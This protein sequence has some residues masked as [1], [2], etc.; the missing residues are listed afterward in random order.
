[1]SSYSEHAN[2]LNHLKK[3]IDGSLVLTSSK[4]VYY[5][6]GLMADGFE[7]LI[8][9]VS[10][11]DRD[12]LLVPSL[13]A[14]EALELN[15]EFEVKAW[16]DSQ[17]STKLLKDILPSAGNIYVESSMK[18]GLYSELPG[19]KKFL[20]GPIEELR[21]V[22]EE[23]EINRMKRA[24]EIAEKSFEE[25]IEEIGEGISE[26]R[27]GMILEQ[28]F[29]ENGAQKAAF[30]SIVAFGK[31]AANP[32]HTPDQTKLH[33]G[34]CIIIDFGCQYEHYNSD[35]T[36]TLYLGT[37]P[38]E[39]Q[40]VYSVVQ[41]AQQA[42]CMFLREGVSGKQT[43]STVRSHIEKKGYG[44]MFFHRTGHGIGL[45]VH[46]SPYVDQ[47]NTRPLISGNCVSVEP[48]IYLNGRFGVRI[49]D[50]LSVRSGP[51]LNFNTL[52]KDLIVL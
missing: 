5:F 39:F 9:F 7:R 6:S 46:E 37:P 4:N 1:M 49:E 2:R 17:N 23:T 45:D 8:A 13:H 51:A 43:D 3:K 20:D 50:I 40:D 14:A 42:G 34:E 26:S 12:V 25:T 15:G 33:N 21:S 18:A 36:R 41:E 24:S 44:E 28:K 48:G 47:N 30:P 35:T 31:N 10:T 32:H 52:K 16:D 29:L 38:E 27:V 19:E 11:P 22:K